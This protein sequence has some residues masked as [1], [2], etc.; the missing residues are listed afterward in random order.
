[1]LSISNPM[2]AAQQ[3]LQAHRPLLPRHECCC[4]LS[5]ILSQMDVIIH[6]HKRAGPQLLRH[7]CAGNLR[8]GSMLKGNCARKLSTLALGA[9]LPSTATPTTLQLLSLVE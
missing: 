8:W 5:N 9:E 1:M 4:S 3:C 6:D 2:A 7:C